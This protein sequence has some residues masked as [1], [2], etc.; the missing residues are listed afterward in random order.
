MALGA[1]AIAPV[2]D[3]ERG[4]LAIVGEETEDRHSIEENL[5]GLPIDLVDK[6]L[7]RELA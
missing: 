5:L 2:S 3:C 4:W 7:E 1:T 6:Y